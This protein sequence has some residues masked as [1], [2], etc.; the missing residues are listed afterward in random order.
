MGETVRFLKP[1]RSDEHYTPPC[2]FA[3]M[4][5]EFDLDPAQPEQGR[6][7]L[8]VPA[9]SFFTK[10]ENGLAQDW[11]GFVW[12]NPPFGG[13]NGVVPWLS[14]FVA[15]GNGVALVSAL[16]SSG[17]FHEFAPKMDA[18][19]FPAGKT[20]FIQPD[21]NIASSPP[22]GVVLMAIGVRGVEALTNAANA[23][24]G[25]MVRRAA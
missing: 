18:M 4:G 1:G 21:G 5:V 25:L 9:H 15:H 2:V 11:C 22:M 13:R 16:T 10:A 19:L 12:M 20:K 3:A 23:G 14:R 17:W 7:F 8:S 6:A 24:Y